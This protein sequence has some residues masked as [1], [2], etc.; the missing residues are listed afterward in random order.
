MS[1][2]QAGHVL[3]VQPRIFTDHGCA[4]AV[5]DQHD[6]VHTCLGPDGFDRAGK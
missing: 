6:P 3:W 1:S 2:N 4:H 5:P